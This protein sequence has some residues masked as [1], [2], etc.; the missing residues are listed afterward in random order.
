MEDIGSNMRATVRETL[1]TIASEIF[2]ARVD[3]VIAEVA[4]GSLSFADGCARIEK[5]V[6]LF[7]G[8]DEARLLGVRLKKLEPQV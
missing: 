5:M 1:G 6:N 8:L 7:I 2:L 4:G 3:K